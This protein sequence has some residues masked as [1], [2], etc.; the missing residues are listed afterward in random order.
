VGRVPAETDRLKEQEGVSRP[1]W[2]EQRLVA[3]RQCVALHGPPQIG[4]QPGEV[5]EPF[6]IFGN[7]PE[8]EEGESPREAYAEWMT[9]KQNPRFARVIANRLW[10]QAF[11]RGLIEPV[12]KL[13]D[14]TKPVYPELMDYLEQLM[15]D[16][17]FDMKQY[18]RILYNTRTYQRQATREQKPEDERFAFT[19]PM[20]RRMSAAQLWD[21]MLALSVPNLDDRLGYDRLTVATLD[22]QQDP[23]ERYVGKSPKKIIELARE[24]VARSEDGGSMMGMMGRGGNWE[25]GK[26]RASELRQPAPVG[27]LL[28]RFGQSDREL[29][30]NGHRKPSVTQV[31]TLMNGPI[32][33][34]L[35]KD[36]S[37]LYENVKSASGVDQKLTVIWRS[38]L[39]RDPDRVEKQAAMAEISSND[40]MQAFKNLVWALL[41]TREFMF[42]R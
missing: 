21:S 27:H 23:Y 41:N 18:L 1:G 22:E 12:D 35:L 7:I 40:D 26:A 16:L 10:K 6:T 4:E 17:D 39:N 9:S 3:A 38:I 28:R 8:I 13:T 34:V 19:G 33:E 20:L 2:T 15:K 14:G 32:D 31:L 30:Q 11:G 25:K 42:I 37:V 5:V 36:K 24:H 29:I